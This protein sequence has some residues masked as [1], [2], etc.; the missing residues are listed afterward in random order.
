M[1]NDPQDCGAALRAAPLMLWW[2]AMGTRWHESHKTKATV[3][4]RSRQLWTTVKLA[5]ARIHKTKA[6]EIMRSR[7][8]L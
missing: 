1:F 4:M 2:K 6:A 8:L 3:I 5:P 7:Q